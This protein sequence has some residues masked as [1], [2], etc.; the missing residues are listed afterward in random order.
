MEGVYI[1][2]QWFATKE[3][4]AIHYQHAARLRA[5]NARELRRFGPLRC[6]QMQR[7]AEQMALKS[8]ELMGVS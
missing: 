5:A 8:R 6:A 7:E 1:D 4:A 2:R 3:D